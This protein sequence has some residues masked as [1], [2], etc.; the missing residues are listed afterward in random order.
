MMIKGVY[1]FD[2][3]SVT[4]TLLRLRLLPSSAIRRRNSF[5]SAS[6]AHATSRQRCARDDERVPL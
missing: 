5:P 6:H 4:S 1:G 2:F 3:R